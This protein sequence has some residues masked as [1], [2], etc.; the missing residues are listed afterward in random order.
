MKR[1]HLKHFNVK[2]AK[3]TEK[4]Q[5]IE[6]TTASIK[7]IDE[8]IRILPRFFK[9]DCI[10]K[11]SSRDY[12]KHFKLI[13][14]ANGSIINNPNKPKLTSINHNVDMTRI[15]GEYYLYIPVDIPVQTN[16]KYTKVCGIDPGCRTFATVY[17]VDTNDSNKVKLSEYTLRKNLLIK[18]NDKLTFLKSDKQIRKKLQ[19]KNYRKKQFS[20]IERK[21]KN[22]VNLLHWDVCNDLLKNNDVI[23]Y[24]DIKS[25]NI[26]KGN[27][28]HLTNQSFN[29]LKFYQFKQR[30]LYKA[31]LYNKKVILVPEQ[32][33]TQCCSACGTINNNVGSSEIYKC[34][35]NNCKKIFGRDANSSKNML[36]K[37]VLQLKR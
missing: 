7:I 19:E 1:G 8:S 36:L 34:K 16:I 5:T 23:L 33:T 30:L 13:K 18:L 14:D 26:V 11:I 31:A 37:G 9:E 15:N 17:S 4:K 21:K 3:K 35:N 20:K 12:K 10:L 6:L 27:K 2:Y 22:I 28:N 32:Y 29:D 25:H 24:G